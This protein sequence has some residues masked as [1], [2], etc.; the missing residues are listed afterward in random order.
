MPDFA[1]AWGG[2]SSLQLGLTAV[3]T[4]ASRRGHTLEEVVRW[5]AGNP[6]AL[7]GL[8]GKGAIAVGADADLVAF[9][10]EAGHTVD[11]SLLH[12][13]NPVTP[14]TAGRSPGWSAPPGYA[15]GSW[16]RS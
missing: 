9:D 10:A 3:W 11:V 13:K 7:A 1:A 8:R 5:M 6:A 12:H 4:E 2:I 14:I 16:I 15:A